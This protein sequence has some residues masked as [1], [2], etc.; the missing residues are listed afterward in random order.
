[1]TN[2]NNN[3]NKSWARQEIPRRINKSPSIVPTQGR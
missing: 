3:N 1:M 2:N